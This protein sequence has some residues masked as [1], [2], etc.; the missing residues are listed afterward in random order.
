[1]LRSRTSR[2]G[3]RIKDHCGYI[4]ASNKKLRV[5]KGREKI[6]TDLGEA[7]R[8]CTTCRESRYKRL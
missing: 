8:V 4:L 5:K 7:A 2:T 6:K 1:V 3:E